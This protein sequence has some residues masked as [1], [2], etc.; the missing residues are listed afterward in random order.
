M[1]EF[2]IVVLPGDG[3]GVEIMDACLALLDRVVPDTGGFRLAFERHA[4]GATHYRDTGV[5]FPDAA[6]KACE[7][8][9]AILQTDATA[10]GM[11]HDEVEHVAVILQHAFWRSG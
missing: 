1:N 11:P 5:A 4:A 6:A 2:H 9:D 7:Q 3:I 10:V 8:C